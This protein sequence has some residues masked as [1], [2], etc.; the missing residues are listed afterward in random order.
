M[1]QL[2]QRALSAAD[3]D[4]G[5]FSDRVDELAGVERALGLGFNV[6]LFGPAGSGKTSLLHRVEARLG[7]GAVYVNAANTASLGELTDR[8][9][10]AID[11]TVDRHDADLGSPA[12]LPSVGAAD[13]DALASLRGA[14]RESHQRSR[15]AVLL[16]GLSSQLRHE[17]FGR[18]RDELWEIPLRWVV[19]GRSPL[20][21]PADTFFEVTLPLGPLGEAA[22]RDLL[23]RR[24]D[25]G[26]DDERQRLSDLA[27][28]LPT[29]LG[30]STPREL[31]AAARS[32]MV[33]SD[34]DAALLRLRRQRQARAG[35]SSTATRV[36][37]ALN[38]LGPTHAGDERL[39]DEIGTTRSRIVQVLRELEAAGLV[40]SVQ[41]GRRRLYGTDVQPDFVVEDPDRGTIAVLDVKE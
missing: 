16:D 9:A 38:S 7:P 29:M 40:V 3:A 2:S 23:R 5:L 24:A 34:P 14:I 8:L 32:V 31:L 10:A 39:L 41:S 36:L 26:N 4:A 17:L 33:S 13:D 12:A 6:Y 27:Q 21:T 37:D 30:L 19:A 18:Q 22:M 28:E 11:A 20:S 1:L 25:T 35:L 15:P